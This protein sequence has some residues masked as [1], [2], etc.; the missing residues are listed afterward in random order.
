MELIYTKKMSHGNENGTQKVREHKTVTELW[1]R[2]EMSES[3]SRIVAEIKGPEKFSILKSVL[4]L[5]SIS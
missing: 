2:T 5:N 1:Q 4:Y 3:G